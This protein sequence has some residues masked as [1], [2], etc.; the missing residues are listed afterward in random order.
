MLVR[1]AL[2]RGGALTLSPPKCLTDSLPA[3]ASRVP[4]YGQITKDPTFLY[5]S[6]MNLLAERRPFCS[7]GGG[8]GAL[9]VA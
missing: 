9:W 6:Y 1:A 8:G 2:P 7:T 5:L 3:L 4:G